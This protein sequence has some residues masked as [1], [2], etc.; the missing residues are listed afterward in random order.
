MT[1]AGEVQ[2]STNFPNLSLSLNAK[3]FFGL[4]A[5][6]QFPFLAHASFSMP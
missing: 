1:L 2:N 5:M 3:Q 6:Q 4:D